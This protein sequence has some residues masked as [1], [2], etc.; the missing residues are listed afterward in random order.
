MGASP[1]EG[2]STWGTAPVLIASWNFPDFHSLS[3]AVFTNNSNF[4]N[5]PVT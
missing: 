5:I 3:S 1:L 4:R 2:A